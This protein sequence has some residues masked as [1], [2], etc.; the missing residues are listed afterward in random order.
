MK[1]NKIILIIVPILVL[2][3]ILVLLLTK[4]QSNWIDEVLKEEYDV[5]S[6]SCDGTT[7][8]LDKET[9]KDIKKNWKNLSDNGPF[10]G[11]INSCHKKIIIDYNDNIVDI[12]IIDNTSIIIKENNKD[13]FYTY[14]TNANALVNQL[15]NY[16]N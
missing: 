10:L 4:K 8:I 16:F 5:Y 7:N 14:Y 12:E 1:K 9:L 11:D 15:N 2:S 3:L 6:L 13:D